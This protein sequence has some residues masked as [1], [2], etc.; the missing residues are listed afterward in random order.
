MYVIEGDSVGLRGPIR[1]YLF[2]IE[3]YELTYL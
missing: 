1:L 3:K 2:V